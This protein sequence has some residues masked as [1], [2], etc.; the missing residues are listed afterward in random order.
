MISHYD[1]DMRA[2]VRAHRFYAGLQ[3]AAAAM[4]LAEE[5]TSSPPSASAAHAT[6][7]ARDFVTF[8]LAECG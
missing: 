5:N 3:A 6:A 8:F 7:G 1:A 4:P 2:A